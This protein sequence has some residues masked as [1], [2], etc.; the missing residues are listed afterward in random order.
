MMPCPCWSTCRAKVRGIDTSVILFKI[1]QWIGNEMHWI[2]PANTAKIQ[3][4]QPK[5]K[6]SSG[7]ARKSSDAVQAVYDPRD[8]AAVA[9]W[10]LQA[11]KARCVRI[12]TNVIIFK[13]FQWIGNEIHWINPANTAKIQPIQPKFENPVDWPADW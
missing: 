12:C 2:N 6:K 1:F 5:F 9:H 4:I 13:I 10:S 11:D 8:D 7:L 3:P